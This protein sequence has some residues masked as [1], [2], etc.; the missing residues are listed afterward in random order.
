MK[1]NRIV[2]ILVL[3]TVITFSVS[4]CEYQQNSSDDIQRRSQ[5][6][7]LAEG[8]AQTG[9]P[10]IVNFR[11]KKILKDI[12]ERRDQN[13]LSTYAYI[14]SSMLGKFT[15]LGPSIGYAI[16]AATQYTNPMKVITYDN[17]GGGNRLYAGTNPS[18][19]P[20]ADPNGLFSPAT[21]EGSWVVMYDPVK[22][23]ALPQYFEERVDVL[24]YKL[25]ARLVIGGYKDE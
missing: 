25:P 1:K 24:S 15:Y 9:M 16:P 8:T 7:I 11:E 4:S 12:I 10:A 3:A 2:F 19:I 20:Q 6:K 18:T 14:Y 5:E 13:G 21:A 22:K 17:T 23:E